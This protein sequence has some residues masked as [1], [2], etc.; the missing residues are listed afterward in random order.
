M[1]QARKY[2]ADE[3][4]AA[5]LEAFKKILKEAD[6]NGDGEISLQEFKNLMKKFFI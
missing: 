3:K 5:S 1:E 2:N 4:N 6:E